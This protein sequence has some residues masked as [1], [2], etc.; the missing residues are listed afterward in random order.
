MS[1]QFVETL[2]NVLETYGKTPTAKNAQFWMNAMNVA[3]ISLEDASK[4][5]MAH[6]LNP[7]KGQFAPKVADV[8]GAVKG[9][10]SDIEDAAASQW[11]IV[12]EAIRWPGSTSNVV[13]DDPK[14]QAVVSQMGWPWLCE[15]YRA[16]VDGVWRKGFVDSYKASNGA[17]YPKVCLGR[18]ADNPTKMIG[19]Q[20]KC[21][22]IFR[23]G[24]PQAETRSVKE[25][26][27]PVGELIKALTA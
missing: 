20:E 16:D 11:L 15:N 12:K 3:G 27:A 9:T 4:A 8:V 21:E 17:S 22:A 2:S 19:N 10:R 24:L 26:A 14:T 7:D 1:R 5:L 25:L 23:Q 6:L 18:Y 13:F